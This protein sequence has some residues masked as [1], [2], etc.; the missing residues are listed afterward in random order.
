MGEPVSVGSDAIQA[1]EN[2]EG[3]RRRGQEIS[4]EDIIRSDV[5]AWH[6]REFCYQEAEGPRKAYSH[7]HGLCRQWLKPE[8]HTKKQML[9]LVILEQFLAILPPEMQSW[10]RECGPE[11]TSQAVALAEGFLLSQAESVKREEE[12]WEPSQ[13]V[14]DPPE[15]EQVASASRQRSMLIGSREKDD[16]S[17][18]ALGNGGSLANRS[19]PSPV[20]GTSGLSLQGLTASFE[21]VAVYFSEEEWAL[22]DP[23]QRALHRVVMAENRRM[24]SSLGDGQES[25]KE[26]R[27]ETEEK[28]EWRK[29]SIPYDHIGF[30][31]IPVQEGSNKLDKW[32]KLPLSVE[33]L[34][35]ESNLST[36][37][38]SYSSEKPCEGMKCEEIISPS[39]RFSR[40]PSNHTVE[41][42]Y[43]CSEC[44]KGFSQRGNLKY[45]HRTH[46]GEKPYNCSVCGKSYSQKSHLNKHQIIHTGEK[47][48]QCS[49]C[50]KR[51]SQS[52]HLVRHERIHTGEKPYKCSVCGKSFSQSTNLTYHEAVHTGDVLYT[53]SVCGKSFSRSTHLLRHERIH[54]GERSVCAKNFSRSTSL[55]LLERIHA[56]EIPEKCSE[57]GKSLSHLTR[58]L[59]SQKIHVEMNS[60]ACSECGKGF[61]HSTCL[62]MHQR[63]H[64]EEKPYTCSE[65][66]K[67]FSYRIHL[68]IH[69][70][71]HTGEKPYTCTECGKSFS[72]NT[73][74]ISHTRIHTGE[75]PYKCSECGKSFTQSTSLNSH[76]RIH[77]GE[78]PY[79]CFECGR[80][81][82]QRSQLT[83]HQRIH[84]GEKPFQC[85][86][87]GKSFSHST[88]LSKHRR[89]HTG[90]NCINAPSVE[91]ASITG[92]SFLIIPGAI[93]ERNGF[94]D[95]NVEQA[96]FVGNTSLY[97][98]TFTQW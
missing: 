2:E 90:K 28:L 92:Q 89:T 24:L 8:R 52:A 46:T 77:T 51:F 17:A 67:G 21:D 20:S 69:Q 88:S 60:L 26:D 91:T 27:W 79:T 80:G 50:G 5:Q 55:T 71:V 45:H 16:Q 6:F 37:Q 83:S 34:T 44:G 94:L 41:K 29:K 3:W 97:I 86:E 65:C 38:G 30:H 87:C 31:E 35:N 12:V 98:N 11:T 81:F 36:N 78:K 61:C 4:R 47:P 54:T 82:H 95:Q 33:I 58:L 75:K 40:H 70:R 42:P 56:G 62:S 7:L 84:T 25:G 72:H 13:D 66:G 43:K 68:T 9:D 14:T 49:V 10:V 96:S 63:I 39:T 59:S 1:V 22:L 15:A 64:T 73:S 18:M 74:L 85:S 48:Y 53:C 19:G 57:C 93:Q 76:R 32:N 23:D